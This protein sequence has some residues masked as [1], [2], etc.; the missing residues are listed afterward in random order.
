MGHSLY[1]DRQKTL[2]V[3][4]SVLCTQKTV[5]NYVNLSEFFFIVVNCPLL[6]VRKISWAAGTEMLFLKL[7]GGL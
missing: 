6:S 1:I 2:E 4:V 5:I 7:P 3:T